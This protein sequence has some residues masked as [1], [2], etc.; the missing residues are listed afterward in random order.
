M[1][2]ILVVPFTRS[3]QLVHQA[4]NGV[5]HVL[6]SVSRALT[7]TDKRLLFAV[8]P[9]LSDIEDFG[10]VRGLNTNWIDL[11]FLRGDKTDA[12]GHLERGFKLFAIRF[13][14]R[15]LSIKFNAYFLLD[16]VAGGRNDVG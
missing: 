12:V 11:A 2:V 4:Q 9:E 6:I 7:G 3:L 15:L 5:I 14:V 10:A 1:D 13:L 16:L 8:G